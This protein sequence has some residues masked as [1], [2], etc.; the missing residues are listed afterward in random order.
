MNALDKNLELTDLGRILARLPI[1]P[2][3]GKMVLLGAALGVGDLMLT[4]GTV[5]PSIPYFKQQ[6]ILNFLNF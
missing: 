6:N 4:A 3:L 1:D 2:K 5:H